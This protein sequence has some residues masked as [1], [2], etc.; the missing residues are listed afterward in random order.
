MSD[1]EVF[2]SSLIIGDKEQHD[3]V[4]LWSEGNP[5]YC[6]IADVSSRERR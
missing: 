4:Q 3:T 1:S 2:E 6:G 5:D